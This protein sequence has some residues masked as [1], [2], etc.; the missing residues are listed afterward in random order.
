MNVKPTQTDV[1]IQ[2][3]LGW[4]MTKS[5]PSVITD[6]SHAHRT[7]NGAASLNS[8]QLAAPKLN[9]E[10]TFPAIKFKDRRARVSSSLI[11]LP[12]ARR[13]V[14]V[15]GK[16]ICKAKPA[17]GFPA[18]ARAVYLV[19]RQGPR[20]ISH[21]EQWAMPNKGRAQIECLAQVNTITDSA[22]SWSKDGK[23][24][25][26]NLLLFIHINRSDDGF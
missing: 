9:G 6:D 19:K 4:T 14:D 10:T 26:S 23:V 3:P 15:I 25:L 12:A 8:I 21:R 13:D 17:D 20:I 24:S 16:Y 22:I 7:E 2:E 5:Q 1:Y 11:T 18:S